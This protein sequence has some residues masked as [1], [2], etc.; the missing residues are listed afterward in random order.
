MSDVMMDYFKTKI[1]QK[2]IDPV[3]GQTVVCIVDDDQSFSV[4]LKDYLISSCDFETELFASGEDFLAQYKPDHRYVVV[5]D[6]DFG[7]KQSLDGMAIL[8]RIMTINPM[9]NVIM[10]SGQ[11]DI[12]VAIETLRRGAL[13]YFI[14]ANKTVFANIASAIIKS[15]ELDKF[16][17]N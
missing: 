8:N 1:K 3:P 6:Y 9:A 12:E 2:A 15:M 10:V 5:L 11:D 17:M 7:D 13:D 16:R 14:K 4:M